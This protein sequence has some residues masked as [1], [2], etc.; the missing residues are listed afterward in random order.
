V[1]RL[2][3]YIPGKPVAQGRPRAVAFKG[4]ARVYQPQKS[5]SY[6]SIVSTYT[7][8]AMGK[9]QIAEQI[10]APVRLSIEFRYPFP[11]SMAKYRQRDGMGKPTKPD[12]DNLLKAVLDGMSVLWGDDAQVVE[13]KA[14]KTMASAMPGVGV[15]VEWEE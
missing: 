2:E 10:K 13:I 8:E 6:Q 15:A 9:A 3:F 7:Y 1:A 14:K 4:H 11:K 12:L 5:M